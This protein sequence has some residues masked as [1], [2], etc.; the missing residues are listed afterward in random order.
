MSH[1]HKKSQRNVN[2]PHAP[3]EHHIVPSS[4]G[5]E[6]Y[7]QNKKV[8]PKNFHVAY[9]KIFAN[10]TPVEVVKY[11][12]MVWFNPNGSFIHPDEWLSKHC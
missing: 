6:K 4:R 8:V 12:K 7:K 11:L 2:N 3:E 5:G 10:L 9:H 1:S